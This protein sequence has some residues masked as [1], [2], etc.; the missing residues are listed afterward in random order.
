M[1]L[2]KAIYGVRKNINDKTQ[3]GRL[4]ALFNY[5]KD[6]SDDLTY[7]G[8]Y[9]KLLSGGVLVKVPLSKNPKV[10]DVLD[11]IQK[12]IASDVGFIKFEARK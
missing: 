7:I 12:A 9:Q 6:I 8:K 11:I 4:E 3:Y 10:K 5:K 2:D 1:E